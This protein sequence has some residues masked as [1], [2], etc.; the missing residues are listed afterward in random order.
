MTTTSFVPTPYVF[1]AFKKEAVDEFRDLVRAGT[2]EGLIKK[3]IGKE[4]SV[5]FTNYANPNFISFS[6][7]IAA[8]DE[9]VWTMK[10][11]L[12]D[13]TEQLENRITKA[14][15][16]P[17]IVQTDLNNN[18]QKDQNEL[19]A[20][21][22]TNSPEDYKNLADAFAKK[23]E[24]Y[25]KK[26]DVRKYYITYGMGA[27]IDTW[28]GVFE[29]VLTGAEI[30]YSEFKK[31]VLTLTPTVAAS[32]SMKTN[33]KATVEPY[34]TPQTG[35]RVGITAESKVIQINKLL[36]PQNDFFSIYDYDETSKFDFE[37][38]LVTEKYMNPLFDFHSMVRDLIKNSIS[39][40]TKNNNVLV[41]LPDLNY[42]FSLTE[43]EI[44]TVTEKIKESKNQSLSR[45][46]EILNPEIVLLADSISE[47]S[48]IER[49]LNIFATKTSLNLSKIDTTRSEDITQTQTPS[50]STTTPHETKWDSLKGPY[51]ARKR[52]YEQNEFKLSKSSLTEYDDG[53]PDFFKLI[54]Q[55]VSDIYYFL[56][57]RKPRVRLVH[58]SNLDILKVWENNYKDDPMFKDLDL[59][60]PVL[61]FGDVVMIQKLYGSKKA[62]LESSSGYPNPNS[63]YNILHP[64]DKLLNDSSFLARM[65]GVT[66]NKFSSVAAYSNLTTVPDTFAYA[67]EKTGITNKDL[68]DLPVFRYNL[69][70]PNILKIKAFA[71]TIYF[72]ELAE[73]F[74]KEVT[75]KISRHL[76]GPY[77][78]E[79][80]LNPFLNETAVLAYIQDRLSREGSS[81]A[82][83]EKIS[84]DLK[85]NYTVNKGLPGV[86]EIPSI[87]PGTP[88]TL[89]SGETFFSEP[90]I[91]SY[92]IT[93][94]IRQ[95]QETNGFLSKTYITDYD[96]HDPSL[97]PQI[98]RQF[99]ILNRFFSIQIETLPMFA[100]SD[101][102]LINSPCFIFA[103]SPQVVNS[104]LENLTK[105][106]L[107]NNYLDFVS[108]SYI[109]MGFKHTI[110]TGK[111]FSE[112]MLTRDLGK[113]GIIQKDQ[114][115]IE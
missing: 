72:S 77:N 61:I 14:C 87:I 104:D 110:K 37:K 98:N 75:R 108:N 48:K 65:T 67:L 18:L 52:Y 83:I 42:L 34:S 106:K 16:F 93:D 86:P 112:F 100:L 71:N 60:N 12:I 102:S 63:H 4:D 111:L 38:P 54:K 27:N 64:K 59:K 22:T 90:E 58:E 32:N 73:G 84:S 115:D 74:Q 44:Y 3:F 70:N 30:Q 43:K 109:F 51:T 85:D 94:L 49:I 13:P 31:V 40:I 80:K 26:V 29:A 99:D 46:G 101:V 33:S 25:A 50:N 56:P 28:A 82:T 62:K 36:D 10:L 19:R 97:Y 17:S 11:E 96:F 23:V 88:T 92:Y 53:K 5:L 8:G 95:V 15:L 21:Q 20:N 89:E 39:S 76:A 103:K 91:L 66:K 57:Q 24:D 55:T 6:H 47:C 2:D 45:S 35:L 69:K 81:Q 7:G 105:Q 79:T 113:T 78:E 41:L 1:V 9:L 107:K 114:E 68:M